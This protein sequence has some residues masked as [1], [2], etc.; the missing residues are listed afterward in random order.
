MTELQQAGVAAGKV[1]DAASLTADPQ[2][3]ARSFFRQFVDHPHF[4]TR[5]HD[6]FPAIWSSTTLEPYRRSPYFGEHMFEI[7]GELAGLSDEQIAEGIG[8]RLFT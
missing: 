3:Q 4:G 5:P 8:D 6:R 2:L 7:Y 1:Q